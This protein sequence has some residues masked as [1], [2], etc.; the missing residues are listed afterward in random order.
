MFNSLPEFQHTSFS[1]TQ[2]TNTEQDK[3]EQAPIEA[4]RQQAAAALAESEQRF[5]AV[6]EAASDAMALSTPD[7][8]VI[9]VNSAYLRLYGYALDEVM[10]K[11]F[12]LIFPPEQRLSAQEQYHLLFEQEAIIPT[13]ET[14]VKR[15]D[16]T[17]RVVE[18][19]YSFL[20]HDG[21]R[22]AMLSIIRDI[23]ERKEIEQRKDDF[24]SIASH[25]LKTPVTSIIGFTQILQKRFAKQGDVKSLRFLDRMD[26]QLNKLTKLISDLL[27]IPKMQT[28]T[29]VYQKERF[30]LA[31]LVQEM[32]ENVQA[33]ISSHQILFEAKEQIEVL[34]D[35]DRIGQVLIN[36]LTNAIKY[37]YQANTVIVRLSAAL[38]HALLS[39]QDF[40]IGIAPL[41]QSKIFERFY[42]ADDLQGK[43]FPGLG[44][45]LYISYEIIQRHGGRIWVESSK[46][47]GSTFYVKLPNH[48]G[49]YIDTYR[50]RVVRS[51][52]CIL[53]RIVLWYI[54]S[55]HDTL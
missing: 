3:S 21:K 9:D 53:C 22:T 46:G 28:A 35:R 17:V 38:D 11:P 45:G 42:Q 20:M 47:K 19:R 49:N 12:A 18:A 41:E 7:G 29:L 55:Y 48:A 26:I 34:G 8:I 36:L 43:T 50:P 32:I 16:G 52:C 54:I 31:E 51:K 40:G 23:T 24:I 15:A 4:E 33:A 13:F 25:E 30:N 14:P 1:G 37:S 6:W 2:K 27:E 10:N 5:H 44:I 39:V